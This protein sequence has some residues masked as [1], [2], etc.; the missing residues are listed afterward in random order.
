MALNFELL[1]A[2]PKYVT[3]VDAAHCIEDNLY[4]PAFSSFVMTDLDVRNI[5]RLADLVTS[6]GLRSVETDLSFDCH[7]AGEEEVR[8]IDWRTVVTGME[9]WVVAE[10][11]H[12]EARIETDMNSIVVIER[13]FDGA[14]SGDTVFLAG[15]DEDGAYIKSLHSN[16]GG[17]KDKAVILALARIFKGDGEDGNLVSTLGTLPHLQFEFEGESPIFTSA[18]QTYF[19]FLGVRFVRKTARLSSS[20][21]IVALFVTDT[22]CLGIID[23]LIRNLEAELVAL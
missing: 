1:P 6:N 12:S 22:N 23:N 9:F 2:A 8:L 13:A 17:D 3:F 21:S 10:E 20:Q 15:D 19:E 5:R 18:M 7:F 4:R 11:K 16:F 14:N